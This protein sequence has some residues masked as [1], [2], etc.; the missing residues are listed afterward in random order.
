LTALDQSIEAFATAHAAE[1]TSRD[2]FTLAAAAAIVARVHAS[3]AYLPAAPSTLVTDAE[4][5]ALRDGLRG[6]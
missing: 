3:P 2:V 6:G 4:L 1:L 5:E